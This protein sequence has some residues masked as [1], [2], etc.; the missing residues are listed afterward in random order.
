MIPGHG[1]L[2][3]YLDR[4]RVTAYFAL[5]P[6]LMMHEHIIKTAHEAGFREEDGTFLIIPFPL[7]NTNDICAMLTLWSQKFASSPILVDRKKNGS[8]QAS[9]TQVIDTIVCILTLCSV[10]SPTVALKNIIQHVLRPCG[11]FLFYEHVRSPSR[12]IAYIQDIV[13][14]IWRVFFDGC[15]I[16]QDSIKVI[17]DAGM[18]TNGNTKSEESLWADIKIWEKEDEDPNSLFYHQL[19]QCLRK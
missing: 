13:A 18:V 8:D 16:G 17:Q 1:H 2:V 9:Q 3:K 12:S 11:Q 5:E 6:N 4:S 15:I 19:G 10:P 7:E 14:P